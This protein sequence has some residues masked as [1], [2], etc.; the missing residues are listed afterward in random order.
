MPRRYNS[1]SILITPFHLPYMR[2]LLFQADRSSAKPGFCLESQGKTQYRLPTSSQNQ[3]SRQAACA[4]SRGL[5]Y[6]YLFPYKHLLHRLRFLCFDFKMQS[7]SP[8]YLQSRSGVKR[9]YPFSG[10]SFKF[11][12]IFISRN[13]NRKSDFPFIT[14][15]SAHK[16]ISV[17]H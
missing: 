7:L 11:V 6:L 1:L 2:L 3:E 8:Q 10:I 17:F 14:D 9:M 5:S 12:S 16:I 4:L 13:Y 15:F